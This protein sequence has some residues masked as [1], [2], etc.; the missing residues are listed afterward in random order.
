MALALNRTGVVFK[1]CD[2]AGHK[3]DSMGLPRFDGQ[4]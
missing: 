3:P 4:G 1:K 2:R